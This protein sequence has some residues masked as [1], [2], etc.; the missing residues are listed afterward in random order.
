MV[1][2]NQILQTAIDGQKNILVIG[3]ARSGTHA[4]AAELSARSI[5]IN[6]KEICK[7]SDNPEPWKEISLLY[8]TPMLTIAQVVQLTAKINLSIDVDT[9]KKHAVVVNIRRRN[10]VKQF[11]SWY[12]F[13]YI[14]PTELH[15]WH[16]HSASQTKIK[17]FSVEASK[18]NIIQFMLEQLVDDYFL[19]DFNLCYEDLNFDT[20]KTFKKNQ[21]SF[22]IETMFFNLNLVKQYL[23]NWSYAPGHFNT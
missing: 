18:E 8:S 7:A 10:K 16:N 6:L 21:F 14:D 12:Y 15:P 4:L 5:S 1:I 23:N 19:P 11:A 2:F 17:Q 3:S 20:Q 13:R 9:I 22:P